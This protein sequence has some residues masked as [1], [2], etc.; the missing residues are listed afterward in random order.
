[1]ELI[2]VRDEKME[3]YESLLLERDQIRKEAEQIW[4][5]YILEFGPLINERY[6]AMIECIK[7]KKII[8]YYQTAINHG[9]KVDSVAMQEYIRQEMAEYQKRLQSMMEELKDY[10]NANVTSVYDQKRSKELYRRLAKLLHPDMYPET[11]R[12]EEFKELWERTLDAYRCN[13][14][15]ELSELEVLVRKV[16][17]DAGMEH[18]ELD[19]PDIEEKIEELKE[20]IEGIKHGIPYIYRELL[21]DD[22]EAKKTKQELKEDL[23]RYQNYKEELD[24][25][26]EALEEEE[27]LSWQMN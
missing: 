16:L 7:R 5:K 18:L 21:E 15:K 24:Q 11:D 8:A 25:I 6:E 22:E 4:V 17:A 26:I 19:V 13:D 23:L 10:Q 2:Q 9:K 1:M 20:E 14:V 3:E 12:K 27:G